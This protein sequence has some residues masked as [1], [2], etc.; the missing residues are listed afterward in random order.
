IK[1]NVNDFLDS[2]KTGAEA[3]D[4]ATSYGN[5][6]RKNT[7]GGLGLKLLQRFIKNNEGRIQIVSAEGFWEY[8]GY[9]SL[10]INMNYPFSG[11]IVNIIFNMKDQKI[12]YL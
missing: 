8:S 5:T 4:W 7:T 9:R 11:T 1:R 6:T 3:I 2:R 10:G 12:H